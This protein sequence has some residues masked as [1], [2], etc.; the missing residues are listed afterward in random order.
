MLFFMSYTT[1]IFARDAIYWP[2]V[3]RVYA[4][5][6][7]IDIK[8]AY[9]CKQAMKLLKVMKLERE[10]GFNVKAAATGG[11]GKARRTTTFDDPKFSDVVG[12]TLNSWFRRDEKSRAELDRLN[13]QVDPYLKHHHMSSQADMQLR[14]LEE[15]RAE[16]N[17][18]PSLFTKVT[19]TVSHL[20]KL[21]KKQADAVVGQSK[22]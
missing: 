4:E 9:D 5:V 1:A 14:T 3:A 22:L 19:M 13:A 2:I 16:M 7:R 18:R 8:R 17:H 11:E 15:C 20:S 12:L 21:A 6:N 10:L